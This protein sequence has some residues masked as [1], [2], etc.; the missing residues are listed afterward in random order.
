MIRIFN[1]GTFLSWSDEVHCKQS[2][3]LIKKK[4]SIDKLDQMNL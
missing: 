2:E 1:A 4:V 3:Y